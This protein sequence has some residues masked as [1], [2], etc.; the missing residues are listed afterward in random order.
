MEDK[1]IKYKT[2]YL[3]LKNNN[4]LIQTGG[5]G[6]NKF[7][8]IIDEPT[9]KY[10]KYNGKNTIHTTNT[11][12]DEILNEKSEFMIGSI[13]KL[14][15]GMMI[16]ILNDKKMLSVNDNIN[17]YIEPNKNNKFE[18]VTINDVVNHKGGIIHYLTYSEIPGKYKIVNSSI[19][20]LKIF[21]K[22]PLCVGEI[23]VKKYSSIGFIILGAIIEKVTGLS[24]M[25]ALQKYI[26]Q[27]CK[28]FNTDIGEPNI[29]IYNNKIS[30]GDSKIKE[31]KMEKYMVNAGGGLYSCISDMV[32]FAK[33][34]PKILTPLQIKRCYSYSERNT[35]DHDGGIYGGRSFFKVEYTDKWKIKKIII[36]LETCT[37]YDY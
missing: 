11:V 4:T 2:K 21:M 33:Y 7:K 30:I 6:G 37:N 15:T 28:M 29:T 31:E 17:K 18:N 22:K 1:Y 8:I 5:G 25:E 19:E 34:I 24:Y 26:L 27:P 13:T 36:E 23:G 16:I 32:N 9:V 20:A 12:D 14:F 10:V 3:E 35:I